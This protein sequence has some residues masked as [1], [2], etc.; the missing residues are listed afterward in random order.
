MKL[1]NLYKILFEN[2][3]EFD[4][5]IHFLDEWTPT[6]NDWQTMIM[7][8]NNH[9]D[10]HRIFVKLGTAEK[11]V[12]YYLVAKAINYPKI[13]EYFD[14]YIR[15]RLKGW[16]LYDELELIQNENIV[17]PNEFQELIDDLKQYD[18]IG[19]VALSEYDLGELANDKDL[20]YA[21]KYLQDLKEISF[22]K[23]PHDYGNYYPNIR[24]AKLEFMN[25]S[26]AYMKIA[27]WSNSHNMKTR[28]YDRSQL[29]KYKLSTAIQIAMAPY[30]DNVIIDPEHTPNYL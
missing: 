21:L 30:E 16:L 28:E 23:S 7:N 12:R 10:L 4:F 6:A 8:M 14:S 22:Q 24:I 20:F 2:E 29:N 3:E 18:K 5:S 9:S 1:Y 19:G 11:I 25:G 26:I 17:I 13:H 27:R 15:K